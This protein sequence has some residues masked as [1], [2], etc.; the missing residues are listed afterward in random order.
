MLDPPEGSTKKLFTLA[1]ERGFITYTGRFGGVPVSIVSIGM[2]YPN[3]DFFVR[4]VREC[5]KG[6]LVIIR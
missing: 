6:E 3:M 2:G 1:S 5:V 4:E